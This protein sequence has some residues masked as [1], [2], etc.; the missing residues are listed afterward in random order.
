MV[1]RVRVIPTG[2]TKLLS[3]TFFQLTSTTDHMDIA[4]VWSMPSC[5]FGLHTAHPAAAP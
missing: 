3:K 1:L 5:S 2:F 4:T